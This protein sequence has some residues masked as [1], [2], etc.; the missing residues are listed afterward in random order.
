MKLQVL[1]GP[2]RDRVFALQDGMTLL[3]GRG[4]TPDIV[5]H[6][7]HV[8]R[9]HCQVKLET[10]AVTVSDCESTSGTFVNGRLV[11]THTMK[12][13]D[14]LRVG[15]TEFKLV[16]EL[17]GTTEQTTKSA[18][19]T[20]RIQT[21]ADGDDLSFLVGETI[22]QYHV[23]KE[24]TQ[25]KTGAIFLARHIATE[26][27]LALKVLW[28][29]V[30]KDEDAMQRF[31]RAMKT[32][33]P[34]RHPNIV[35]IY[36]AGKAGP[37]CWLA[38]EYVNGKSVTQLIPRIGISGMLEWQMAYRV[39]V[40]IGRALQ[41]AAEH[42]IIHRN[43]SPQNILVQSSDKLTKLG[44]LMLAKAFEG[45]TQ[46]DITV[47]G[48]LVGDFPY[49]SPEATYG[50]YDLDARSDIY[51][52][53]A[54]VYSLLTGRPPLEAGTTQELIGKIRHEIPAPPQREGLSSNDEFE[55]IVMKMLEK[56]P[57]DRYQTPIQLLKDLEL[58]GEFQGIVV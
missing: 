11:R 18:P 55:R 33:R 52:L 41:A 6:D 54:T 9:K 48:E 34:I 27:L 19:T 1:I 42:R 21:V 37:Y 47:A 31:V 49:M 51:S 7:Q 57:S 25:G 35:R 2:D 3:I 17:E 4:L 22:H 23:E 46:T 8:S 39:A 15:K 32:M 36:N 40:H 16:G 26:K 38:M 5:L 30:S 44:D 20:W 14:R 45:Q 24:I 53:G 12:P 28:P 29:S 10:D 13:G 50:P 43:I 56:R 58:V